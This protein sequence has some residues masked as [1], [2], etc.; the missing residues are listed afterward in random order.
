MKIK[1]VLCPERII[2]LQ[3]DTRADMIKT[4]VPV[5][6]SVPGMPDA[7]ELEIAFLQREDLMSTG[8]GMGVG[9]PHV[10]LHNINSL[11][12]AIGIH[13][14]GI[15]DYP[16]T[17]ND[18]VKIIAMIAAGASLHGAYINMLSKIVFILKNKATRAAI[19]NCASADEIYAILCQG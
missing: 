15:V 1:D 16:T 4:L 12:M 9:V 5:L 2:F 7:D 17:D 14:T 10:R 18:P 19:L 3:G 11:V 6:A 13:P 8:I